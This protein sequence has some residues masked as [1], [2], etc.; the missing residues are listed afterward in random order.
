MSEDEEYDYCD[1]CGKR[2]MVSEIVGKCL[3]CR[4]KKVCSECAVIHNNRVYCVDHAPTPQQPQ[5]QPQPPK[6]GCFIATAAY[7]TPMAHEIQVLRDFRDNVLETSSFGRGVTQTYYRFSPPIARV[8]ARRS[9]MRRT[10]R[11]LLDPIVN[12]FH[13]LEFK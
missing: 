1:I 4:G 3:E 7:G 12:F 9:S 8:I 10:I 13:R 11:G 6:S 2:V 5:P